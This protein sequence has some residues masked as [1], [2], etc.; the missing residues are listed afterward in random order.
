MTKFDD[1]EFEV[2]HLN[3]RPGDI[4][5]LRFKERLSMDT[6]SRMREIINPII[7]TEQMLGIGDGRRSC[8]AYAR[9]N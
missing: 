9:G 1:H 8:R 6:V 4:L 3:L 2:K 5:V 7:Q